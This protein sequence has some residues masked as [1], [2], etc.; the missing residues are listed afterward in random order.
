MIQFWNWKGVMSLD[1]Q[2]KQTT[3]YGSQSTNNQSA[4]ENLKQIPIFTNAQNKL[5]IKSLQLC[6]ISKCGVSWLIDLSLEKM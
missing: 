5:Q 4:K 1:L 6:T 3:T 2:S